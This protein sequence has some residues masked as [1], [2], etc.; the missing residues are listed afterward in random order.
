MISQVVLSFGIPFALIPLIRFTSSRDLMG[1]LVNRRVTTVAAVA[2]AAVIIALNVFLLAQTFGCLKRRTCGLRPCVR[3]ADPMLD[4]SAPNH[5][6]E[7]DAA[8]EEGPREP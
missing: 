2:V 8:D 3:R 4:A 7:S 1:P 6:D 5:H